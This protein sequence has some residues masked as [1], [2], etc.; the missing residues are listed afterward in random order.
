M[1][2]QPGPTLALL[3]RVHGDEDEYLLAVY[4]VRQEISEVP[5]T[6]TVR[7]VTPANPIAWAAQRLTGP[8]D[9]GNLA[10]CFAGDA[11]GGPTGVLAASITDEVITA[12]DF[13]ID[14]HSTGLR[15][16]MPL[17]CGFINE[18]VIKGDE[19]F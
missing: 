5:L 4:R 13:L 16:S 1:S 8:L 17:F 14:L 10:R 2:L 15:Y 18:G 9:N 6:G 7:A 12:A 11:N 19:R 3:G